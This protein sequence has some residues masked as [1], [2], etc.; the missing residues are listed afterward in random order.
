[1]FGCLLSGFLGMSE[2]CMNWLGGS[3][4]LTMAKL[5]QQRSLHQPVCRCFGQ[6]AF[7]P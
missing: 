2:W 4:T 6:L 7:S 3:L 1:M 5:A